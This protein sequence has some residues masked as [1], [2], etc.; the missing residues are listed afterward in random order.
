MHRL[1]SSYGLG[2]LPDYS[3]CM[4]V[5]QAKSRPHRARLQDFNVANGV[6]HKPCYHEMEKHTGANALPR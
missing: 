4:T 6:L 1:H 3:L 2:E 5:R